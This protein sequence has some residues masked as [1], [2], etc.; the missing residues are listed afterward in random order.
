MGIRTTLNPLKNSLNTYKNN[1]LI[2]ESN[3]PGA[4]EFTPKS[5]CICEITIVGAGA[6]GAFNSSSNRPSAAAGS[7]GSGCILRVLLKAGKTYKIIV[8]KGGNPSGGKDANT[9]GGVG[10]S[11]KIILDDQDLITAFGGNGGHVWWPNAAAAATPPA[12]CA[13][14]ENSEVFSVIELLLNRQGIT[15]GTY[16]APGGASV[17]DGTDH[18]HG[19][20]ATSAGGGSTATAGKAGYVKIVYKR[21]KKKYYKYVY[22][23]WTQPVLTSDTSYGVVSSNG[24]REGQCQAYKALDGVKSGA[25]NLMQ[26]WIS[27]VNSTAAFWKWQLPVKLKINSLTFYNIFGATTSP[28]NNVYTAQFFADAAATIPLTEP[29][30]APPTYWASLKLAVIH[31][32]STDIIYLKVLSYQSGGLGMGELEITA[33][34][35]VG[36]IEG[37]PNDYDFITYEE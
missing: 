21:L 17:I 11:S 7:S 13:F 14:A 31:N 5:N 30:T 29:F 26:G 16:T 37:T 12:L 28:G 24:I 35:V 8:G 4:Y 20:S 2:F 25:S 15:G 1:E 19:G 9:W 36:T 27:N 23:N 22:A 32:S 34:A 18:G 10:E 3:T 6:G 33:E